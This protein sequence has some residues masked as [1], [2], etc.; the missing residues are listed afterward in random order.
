MR[1]LTAI[2]ILMIL[3]AT[4][5]RP[6]GAE[7]GYI[8]P[9]PQDGCPSHNVKALIERISPQGEMILRVKG[10]LMVAKITND[11]RYRIPGYKQ[12][13]LSMGVAVQLP[14]NTE[15][16]LR[17]CHTNGEVLFMRVLSLPKNKEPEA[18]GK[19]KS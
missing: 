10:E 7:Q 18:K 15:A 11:T 8:P 12:K 6:Q 5:A 3:A 1:L 14:A 2:G 19:S 4:P 9:G 16:R 17:I 13:T